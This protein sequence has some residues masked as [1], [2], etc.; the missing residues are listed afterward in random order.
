MFAG[1]GQV[2]GLSQSFLLKQLDT[3]PVQRHLAQ[4]RCECIGTAGRNPA[5]AFAVRRSEYHDATIGFPSKR[6]PSIRRCRNWARVLVTSV[7][8][9]DRFGRRLVV[10]GGGVQEVH[11]EPTKLPGETWVE[12]ASYCRWTNCI[13]AGHLA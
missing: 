13:T 12:S 2:I 3:V 11:H 1:V 5:N 8:D 7:R 6:D 4:G 10:D 9:N